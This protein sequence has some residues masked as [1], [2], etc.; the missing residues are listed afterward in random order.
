MTQRFDAETTWRA[1]GN[2]VF[3][4]TSPGNVTL[5]YGRAYITVR[6]KGADGSSPYTAPGITPTTTTPNATSPGT[7]QTPNTTT[8]YQTPGLMP[9]Q[10]PYAG[11]P[12][13]NP[14]KG[15]SPGF[16]PNSNT[17]T[18]TPG[19][20]P[21]TVQTPN[22]TSPGVGPGT[23]PYIATVAGVAGT[24]TSVLGIPFPGGAISQT[25]TPVAATE[26]NYY[27]FPVTSNTGTAFPVSVQAAV[28]AGL[29]GGGASVS[30]EID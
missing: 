10:V 26:I 17:P 30:V 19:V 15:G 25:A 16:T 18:T 8:T 9:G 1:S 4:F 23:V 12:G 21:G 22:A 11:T 29:G 7:V 3:Q 2:G 24:P 20:G 27:N 6:G 28:P 5:P 13:V 14:A